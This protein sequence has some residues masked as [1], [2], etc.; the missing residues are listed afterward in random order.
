MMTK[1][2][3]PCDVTES[4]WTINTLDSR[5]GRGDSCQGLCDMSEPWEAEKARPE[6]ACDAVRSDIPSKM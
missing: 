4:I 1:Y 5:F 6:A 3:S 2:V